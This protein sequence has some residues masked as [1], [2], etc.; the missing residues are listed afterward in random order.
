MICS[1]YE[2]AGRQY[3]SPGEA[4]LVGLCTGTLAAAAIS[5]STSLSE[6]LPAAVHTVQVAFRLGLC[7]Q[8]LRD[9][10][11][12]PDPSAGQEWSA[13]FF[14]LDEASAVAAIAEFSESKV[15]PQLDLIKNLASDV[16]TGIAEHCSSVD[17]RNSRQGNDYQRSSACATVA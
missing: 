16:S 5:S 9:R 10:I 8:E 2:E 11:H 7:G 1:Y 13:V 12:T 4:Y 17:R 6:L 3:P 14:G 15:L